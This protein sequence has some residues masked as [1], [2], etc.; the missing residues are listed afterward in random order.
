MT[1]KDF[2]ILCKC[3][4]QTL[5]YYDKIGLLKPNHVD[6][7]TGYR[8]YEETQAI[9]FVK[10]KN[11]QEAEFSIEQIRELLS[12]PDEEIYNAFERKIM[13]Q[14]AK[15]EHIKKIQTTYLS[16]KQLMEARIKEVKEL[17]KK[18]ALQVNSEEEFGISKDDYKKMI[19]S[20]NDYFEQCA[21]TANSEDSTLFSLEMDEV[22]DGDVIELDLDKIVE[23]A[24]IKEHNNPLKNDKYV[25]IYEMH[26]WEKTVDALKDLPALE[27]NSSEYLFYFELDKS[28]ASNM[29]YCTTI[30]G[31]A[32]ERNDGKKLN[33]SCKAYK[34]KDGENHFWLL[35][36][37]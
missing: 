21:R 20:T 14:A 36:E 26:L 32:L 15:L 4:P 27:D 1:I 34:S 2:A 31:I 28:K 19:D 30:L 16:Q 6:S 12:K 25:T 23:N 22:D 29:T 13:E 7:W 18:S 11:L 35:K 3:N 8:H 9:D 17:I 33:L 37:K 10:I 5:R 24:T